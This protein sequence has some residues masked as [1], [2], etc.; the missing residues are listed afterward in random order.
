MTMGMAEQVVAQEAPVDGVHHP[1]IVLSHGALGD[2]MGLADFAASLANAGFV[3]ASVSHDEIAPGGII[4]T[5]DRAAQLRSLVDD[6]LGGWPGHPSIDAS[7]IGA[8]GGDTVLAAVGGKP[9]PARIAPHCKQAPTERSCTLIGKL[10]LARHAPPVRAGVADPRIRPAVLATP[11]VGY[12]FGKPE[13]AGVHIPVQLWEAGE[14]HVLSE[15]WNAESIRQDL[16]RPASS[17]EVLGADHGD[18]GNVCSSRQIA[19]TPGLCTDRSGFDRA[20]LHRLVD[21]KMIAFFRRELG[22]PDSVLSWQ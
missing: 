12:V 9:D 11:G 10:D 21:D 4:D 16:P 18:F 6:A 1:L 2:R 17:R 15:P 7:A 14:D 8:V 22:R 13:L 5:V 20:A 19:I 3:V